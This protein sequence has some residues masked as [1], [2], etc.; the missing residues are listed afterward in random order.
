MENAKN[1]PIE[2]EFSDGTHGSN[3]TLNYN[4]KKTDEQNSSVK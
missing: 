2:V 1:S 3:S 4:L